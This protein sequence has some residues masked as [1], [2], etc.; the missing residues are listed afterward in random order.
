MTIETAG[1]LTPGEYV[2]QAADRMESPRGRL[3]I[4]SCRSG[5]RVANSV[6]DRYERLLAKAGEGRRVARLNSIDFQFSDG[7]TNVRL[8]VDVNG[9]DVFLFQSL[10]DPLSGRSVDQ[11]Y[12]AF[13]IAARAFR[14]WGAGHVTGVLPYLAYARQDKPT[15]SKREPTTAELMAD[16]T[17]EAGVDRVVVWDPHT[18]RI[19]GFYG[20]VPVDGLH[21]MALF[22]NK[23]AAF[24]GREDVIAVAPDAGASK[25]ITRFARSLGVSSAIAAKHRPRPEQ[26]EV[27]EVMGDFS[28][29]T[30]AVVLDDM[31]NTG[32]TVNA[33]IHKLVKEKGVEEVYLGVS[34]NLCNH[35]AL[36]RLSNLHAEWGLREVLVTDSVPQTESFLSLP[37]LRVRSLDDAFA[38]VI[39]QIHYSRPVDQNLSWSTGA[40]EQ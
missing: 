37:F 27:S 31:I 23:Y 36:G 38:R 16:L 14:E 20:S 13:L 30:T 11:N 33:T 1:F 3:L 9:D 21:P 4:A 5:E 40:K 2:R 15:R 18:D 22:E 17:I 26:A 8:D 28:G 24:A 35:T 12:V 19:H 39:N 29:K 25:L 32:G 10:Y 34:H 7:E 6:G